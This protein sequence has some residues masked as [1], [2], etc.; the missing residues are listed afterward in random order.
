LYLT[1]P[2][3][4]WAFGM[5]EQHV[6]GGHAMLCFTVSPPGHKKLH[7]VIHPEQF[8]METNIATDAIIIKNPKMCNKCRTSKITNNCNLLQALI[9]ILVY[10][11]DFLSYE[12]V[13]VEYEEDKCTARF[14]ETAQRAGFILCLYTMFYSTCEYFSQFSF[15]LKYYRINITYDIFM[16]FILTTALLKRQVDL[17]AVH[18]TVDV[19]AEVRAMAE[20]FRNRLRYILDDARSLEKKDAAVN[21]LNIIFSLNSLSADYLEEYYRDFL[22]HIKKIQ[23]V[24]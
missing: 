18:D 9:P 8:R 7:L 19:F 13:V 10:F 1:A 11:S 14:V 23:A 6:L 22:N 15:I 21:A 12:E 3:L 17:D 24:R 20:E 16:H 2:Q 5:G 4:P